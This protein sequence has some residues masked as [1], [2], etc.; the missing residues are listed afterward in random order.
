MKNGTENQ[1]DSRPDDQRGAK[2]EGAAKG[3]EPKDEPLTDYWKLPK[4]G[5]R[6]TLL[7]SAWT[8]TLVIYVAII[9]A[10]VFSA[11]QNGIEFLDKQSN[12]ARIAIAVGLIYPAWRV[13][14]LIS[15]F[16][17][18]QGIGADFSVTGAIASSSGSAQPKASKAAK[19][20]SVEARME[21]RRARLEKAR[22]EG[23]I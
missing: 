10:V 14:S 16:M 15:K 9:A 6:T 2:P 5:P 7:N 13:G 8:W 12:T 19:P 22:K 20:G 1:S 18:K 3:T 4:T 21:A 11:S 23:K 17:K